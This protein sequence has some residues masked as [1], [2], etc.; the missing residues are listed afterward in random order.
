MTE[1]IKPML[2]SAIKNYDA[3][4]YPKLASAKLDGIRCIINNGVVYSRSGKPIRSKAVQ[5]LFG[6]NE[7]NMLDGEI[8]YG[9]PTA[10]NVF[11]LTTSFV[12]SEDIP[13]GMDASNLAL[14]V[15]DYVSDDYA[16]L[17]RNQIAQTR[18]NDNSLLP[19][20]L[21]HQ[22]QVGSSV[23]MLMFEQMCLTKGYEGIMLRNPNGMY[24]HGRATE[25]SQDLLKVKRFEDAEATVIGY[26]EEMYNGNEATTNE[27]GRTERS[28]HKENLVGKN[29]L[30][31][32]V[33]LTKDNVQFKIGTGYDAEMRKSLW[34]DK[35]NLVGKIVKYKFFPVGV[36][37]APRLPV[38]LGWRD[39]SD[40]SE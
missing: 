19:L 32:L 17:R 2:A 1:I 6:H 29:S 9:S 8:I 36:L 14:F 21:V 10:H 5:Q 7:L 38:F 35:E 12:M 40:M 4:A 31:A 13:E 27:L 37:V 24:K 25:K 39:E 26:E 23:D 30:G 33:C 20:E 11:N 34:Y 3:I 22:V 18:I 16:F 15:F 28:Q